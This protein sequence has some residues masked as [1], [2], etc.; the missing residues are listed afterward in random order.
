M[1]REKIAVPIGDRSENQLLFQSGIA[2]RTNR[3]SNRR[4]PRI[5]FNS[6]SGINPRTKTTAIAFLLAISSLRYDE[7]G[8]KA[9]SSLRYDEVGK[10][11]ISSLRYDEV[12]KKAISSLRYD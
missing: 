1:L 2:P 8:K 10:K 7:L 5:Y 6:N 12:G 3:C 9:I 4:W 11:A